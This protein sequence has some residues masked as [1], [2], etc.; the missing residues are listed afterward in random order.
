MYECVSGGRTDLTE[1]T[2]GTVEDEITKDGGAAWKC[3]PRNSVL[4]TGD[5]L[6]ASTWTADTGCTLDNAA[7]IDGAA[8]KV[9]VTA[10]PADADAFTLVNHVTIV[11]LNGDTEEFDRSMY[12]RITQT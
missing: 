12:I 4:K 7:I 5:T 10:V 2:W 9:R 1:P 8:T 3:L 11:R 6:T